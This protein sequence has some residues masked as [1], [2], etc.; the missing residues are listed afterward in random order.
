[1][2]MMRWHSTTKLRYCTRCG[3]QIEDATAER[4]RG[5]CMPCAN[6]D[7]RKGGDALRAA[8]LDA[9]VKGIHS[10]VDWHELQRG[11]AAL[12][13]KTPGWRAR[14]DCPVSGARIGSVSVDV[15]ATF[16]NPSLKADDVRERHLSGSVS[17]HVVV[18]CKNWRRRIPQEVVVSVDEIVATQ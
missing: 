8:E 5:L 4:T 14:L 11:V 12:F 17:F 3:H 1:M 13:N 10:T 9:L 18:E 7:R 16:Q 15:L 6:D 2:N